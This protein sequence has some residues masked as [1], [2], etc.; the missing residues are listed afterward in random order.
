[1]GRT[2]FVERHELWDGDEHEQVD[3]VLHAV[4]EN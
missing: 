1:M 2:D 3:R 4:I